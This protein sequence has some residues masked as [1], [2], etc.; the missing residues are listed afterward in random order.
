MS[1]RTL[2]ALVAGAFAAALGALCVTPA[3]AQE[4]TPA[5]KKIQAEHTEQVKSGK[6]EPC[7]GTALKGQNDCYAGAGT[8]CAGTS[9]ADYQ[10]NAFKLVPKGTCTTL[11]TPKGQ[12][13]LTPKA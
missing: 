7:F 1:D 11:S 3:T 10:G 13:S 6:V 9:T 5:Q 4:F 12:G 8:T 2:S